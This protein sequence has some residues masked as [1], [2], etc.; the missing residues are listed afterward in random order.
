MDR[1]LKKNSL[2]LAMA[3]LKAGAGDRDLHQA[4]KYV[5]SQ[6]DSFV[7]RDTGRTEFMQLVDLHGGVYAEVKA[8]MQ[9]VCKTLVEP[10]S[11][12]CPPPF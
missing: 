5:M 12:Y 10:R 9:S 2:G 7:L 6:E 3:W 8:E 1:S 11:V 4:H